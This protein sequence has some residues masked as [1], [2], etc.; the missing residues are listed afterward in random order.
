MAENQTIDPIEAYLSN[1]GTNEPQFAE[2]QPVEQPQATTSD[3]G[4]EYETQTETTDTETTVTEPTATEDEEFIVDDDEP[5]AP[6]QADSP[7][8]N[9]K[10]VLGFDVTS[11]DDIKTVLSQK[12]Q[13]FAT[14]L[15]SLK[16]ANTLVQSDELKDLVS[17]VQ[18]GGK[19]ADFKDVA[20]EISNLETQRQQIAK[21]DPKTA[22]VAHLKEDL[23][24]TD[25]QIEDYLATKP[26]VEISIEGK[27]LIRQWDAQ[28]ANQIAEKHQHIEKVK[29]KTEQTYNNLV[30]GIKNTIESTKSLLGVSVVPSDKQMLSKLAEQPLKTLRQFF[31]IDENGNYDSETWAKNIALLALANKKAEVLKRKASSDGAR[32]V[33]EGRVNIQRPKSVSQ[34]TPSE[35][36]S[37]TKAINDYVN[38]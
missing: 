14:K 11:L 28:V 35:M 27:K 20:A 32:Q 9:A 21:I 25:E 36:D 22:F 23:E 24:L 12:E 6:V 34:S 17:H 15:E 29:A 5:T 33:V 7:F 3:D 16:E 26:E 2:Q 19:V 18:K 37:L 30:N 13:E 38:S 1:Q 10:E 8:A 31:P 4:G